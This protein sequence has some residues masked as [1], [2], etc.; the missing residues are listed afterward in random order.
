MPDNYKLEKSQFHINTR[1][2]IK[3]GTGTPNPRL[4]GLGHE[5]EEFKYFDKNV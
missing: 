1:K 5:I 3:Q 4:T 2:T